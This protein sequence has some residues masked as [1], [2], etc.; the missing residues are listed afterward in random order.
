M[1]DCI[2]EIRSFLHQNKLCNNSDKTEFLLIGTPSQFKNINLDCIA[3]DSSTIK[4]SSHVKNLGVIF[5]RSMNMDKQ[6]NKMCKNVYFNIRNIARIR[7]SLSKENT[8]TI[9]NA[10]VTPHL[11]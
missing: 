7:R 5:D 4:A 6:V 9:V 3:V 10:L 1:E 2:Q 11:D 8:K